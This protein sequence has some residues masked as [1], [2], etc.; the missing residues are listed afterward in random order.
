M[1]SRA[2]SDLNVRAC[3][4]LMYNSSVDKFYSEG[5]IF[6]K[7]RGCSSASWGTDMS[8]KRDN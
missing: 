6:F 7:N 4:E 1:V 8:L 3:V 2:V 5:C